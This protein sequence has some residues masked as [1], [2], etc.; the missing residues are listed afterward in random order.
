M[1]SALCVLKDLE[2]TTVSRCSP[3]L[4]CW[5][6]ADLVWSMLCVDF[7]LI[8]KL[9]LEKRCIISEDFALGSSRGFSPT[10]STVLIVCWPAKS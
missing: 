3:P 7:L 1:E 8:V 4:C 9:S 2:V 6:A 5:R 10:L